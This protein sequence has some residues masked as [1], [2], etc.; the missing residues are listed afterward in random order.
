LLFI[1]NITL[2]RIFN[3]II[4]LYQMTP[5]DLFRYQPRMYLYSFP[6]RSFEHSASL[7]KQGNAWW[8]LTPL[9]IDCPKEHIETVNRMQFKKKDHDNNM[10][11]V[12]HIK[13]VQTHNLV[14]PKE[15]DYKWSIS[16]CWRF[17]VIPFEI[18]VSLVKQFDAP[19]WA[20][21]Q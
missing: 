18:G 8:W 4:L 14:N 9:K 2:L 21:L 1:W 19:T 20:I 10:I 5:C 16:G 17:N 15:S 12:Y 7:V 13:K 6:L 11:R 3:I